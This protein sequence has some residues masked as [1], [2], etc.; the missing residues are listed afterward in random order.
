MDWN[1]NYF[2]RSNDT[3]INYY[4]YSTSSNDNIEC[5][6]ISTKMSGVFARVLSECPELFSAEEKENVYYNIDACMDRVL[7]M[8]STDGNLVTFPYSSRN[9][10]VNDCIHHAF[11]LEGLRAYQMYR[12]I[13]VDYDVSDYTEYIRRC[14]ENGFIYSY[15]DHNSYRCFDTDAVR[16]IEDTEAE[17]EILRNAYVRYYNDDTDIRQMAF[18]FNALGA[19]CEAE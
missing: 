12:G 3:G 2:T 1:K 13:S 18:L 7:E 5:I 10:T 8:A 19:Y 17:E 15:P 9:N 14:T 4:W 16:W 6:N 11:I